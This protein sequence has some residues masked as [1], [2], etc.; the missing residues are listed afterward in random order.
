MLH[1]CIRNLRNFDKDRNG[2]MVLRCI[3][4]DC[5]SFLSLGI[6][7]ASYA[8]LASSSALLFYNCQNDWADDDNA[9]L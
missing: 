5:L 3:S 2:M 4:A 8:E 7:R 9:A 6:L 1:S